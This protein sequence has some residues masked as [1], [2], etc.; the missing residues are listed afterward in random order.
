MIRVNSEKNYEKYLGNNDNNNNNNN[1]YIIII[2]N[3]IIN[4]IDSI[5]G[6]NLQYN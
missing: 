6:N 2:N 3:N 4:K 5:F 1:N